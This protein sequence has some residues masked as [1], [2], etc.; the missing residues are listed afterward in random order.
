[1]PQYQNNMAQIAF[2][3]VKRFRMSP[4]QQIW[5][6][7]RQKFSIN[8][9]HK[10]SNF[11]YLK[12]CVFSIITF[13]KDVNIWKEKRTNCWQIGLFFIYNVII[14]LYSLTLTFLA[15]LCFYVP[16]IQDGYIPITGV[17][18]ELNGNQENRSKRHIRHH[19][20]ISILWLTKVNLF[21]INI[22][23]NLRLK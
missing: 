15:L 12:N 14:I 11:F 6:E 3:K 10:S 13:P 18:S 7:I 1:M 16:K 19:Y 20:A 4:F 23:Q 22:Q 21:L 17:S 9:K 2:H 8:I 5:S